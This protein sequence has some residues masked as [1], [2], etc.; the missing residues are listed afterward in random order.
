MDTLSSSPARGPFLAA[1]FFFCLALPSLVPA[2]L[3]SALPP[4]FFALAL[5][6][7]SLLHRFQFDTEPAGLDPAGISNVM[8]VTM[9]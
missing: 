3:T 5:A 2:A 4:I 8:R 6:F 1:V 9:L 7:S